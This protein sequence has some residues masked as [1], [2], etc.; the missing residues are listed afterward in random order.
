MVLVAVVTPVFV[1]GALAA[2]ALLVPGRVLWGLGVVGVF[3]ATRVVRD[4]RRIV[5]GE[6]L[7]DG[8]RPELRAIVERLCVLADLPE[9]ELVVHAERQ[10]NSWV[11]DLPGRPP[12]MHVTTGL[13]ETLEPAELEAVIA[14]ELSHVA[15]RDAT[16][17]TVVGLPGELLGRG[18]ERGWSGGWFL[19]LGQ[20]VAGAIAYVSGFGTRA[21]SRH[22]ELAADA[23]AAR[24]TGRPAALVSA[25]HK[26]SGEIGR[27]PK[28]D[29]R[30]TATLD[31]FG[32]LPTSAEDLTSF[33]DRLRATHPPL[34]RRI[35]ALERLEREMHGARLAPPA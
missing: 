15:H 32:L 11:F 31:A 14:H 21:L 35:A 30:A 34:A 20:I 13:L 8:E 1:L 16:V 2:A 27:L 4:R 17:M 25:L 28:Q 29:L 24:L 26:V 23:G 10:P 19:W 33:I 12:R 7:A 9:P 18:S 22:R 6:P 5:E 3:G